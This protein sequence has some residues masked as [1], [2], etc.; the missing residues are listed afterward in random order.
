[1]LLFVIPILLLS[2]GVNSQGNYYPPK[3]SAA[4]ESQVRFAIENKYDDTGPGAKKPEFAYKTYRTL[5][6]ALTGYLDDP[7]TKLPR[8]ERAKAEQK[9]IGSQKLAYRQFSKEMPVFPNAPSFG[10]N[11]YNSDVSVQVLHPSHHQQLGYLKSIELEKP[12]D[13]FRFH[14]LQA[15]KGSPLNLAHFTRDAQADHEFNPNPQYTFSY[16]VHDKL[17]G[18]S[19]SA[20]ETR[21][22]G[23][24][25]GF[26]SFRDADGKQRTVQYT[27]D[28]KRGFRAIVR[29]T[30]DHSQ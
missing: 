28:D 17:T 30:D 3:K 15:V 23:T 14:K 22:G 10:K 25:Q 9:L 4:S 20:H 18:D 13:P 12:K 5:E 1:M 11:L 16:G 21:D 24:V 26:Y 6:E 29:R 7:D 2:S 8:H 27:A 19:K